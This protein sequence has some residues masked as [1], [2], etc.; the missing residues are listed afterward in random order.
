MSV[1]DGFR[2]DGKVALVT[3]ASSGIGA[4]LARGLAAAGAKVVAAGRRVDRIEALVADIEAA[5]GNAYALALDVTDRITH[6]PAFEAIETWAGSPVDVL[7]NNAGIAEPKKFLRMDA[8][9]RDRTM[10]TNFEGAWDL[11][12]ETAKRL[13]AARRPGSIINIA[14]ILGLNSAP[15]YAAYSASKGAL[16]MMTKALAI[17][18]V[19]Q[20]I[21]V[22]AIAPGWFVTEMNTD[23]FRSDA[24]QA[25]LARTPAA[26]TGRLPELLGPV[27]LLASD[28]GSFVNGVVL[29]VDGGHSAALAG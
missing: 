3:G 1:V 5:G 21:R 7:V 8:A 14:S 10:A 16:I 29:P 23:Y 25:M 11:A 15:G 13:V 26:R 17:E 2:L 24:G 18:L 20:G 12:H 9:S 4:S 19:C 27:L 28:A 6:A 22:N